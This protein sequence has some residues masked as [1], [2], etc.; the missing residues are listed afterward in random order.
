MSYYHEKKNSGAAFAA[1]LGV[2]I[3]VCAAGVYAWKKFK[4]THPNFNLKEYCDKC[5]ILSDD[6]NWECD[7]AFDTCDC[8]E[9]EYEPECNIEDIEID[10]PVDD[11][12]EEASSDDE[13]SDGQNLTGSSVISYE[14][15]KQ[16]VTELAKKL[17]STSD[18][19]SE[20]NSDNILLSNDGTTRK[21]Y[22]FWIESK[23]D[24]VTPLA[25]FYVDIS[26]GEVFDNSERGMK[27]ISD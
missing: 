16:K 20:G 24:D 18:I 19:R 9:P 22:M 1:G 25:V 10:M 14:T 5:G 26:T 3:A 21:C 12:D 13:E 17:Y 27:K 15:A 8:V 6:C 2:G 7:D 4:E 23:T 11:E